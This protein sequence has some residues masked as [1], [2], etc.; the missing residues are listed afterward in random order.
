MLVQEQLDEPCGPAAAAV[1]LELV[2][3]CGEVE[4]AV[5]LGL[6]KRPLEAAAAEDVGEVQEV[7]A[8]V[9]QGMESPAVVSSSISV[10][11][12]WSLT[13]ACRRLERNGT[14]TSI[15]VPL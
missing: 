6:V 3:D 9:V 13:S 7:R 14:A 11:E 10:V 12:R 5:D 15:F 2:L 1:A 4:D 8:T